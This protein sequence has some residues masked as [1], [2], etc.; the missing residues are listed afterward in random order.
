MVKKYTWIRVDKEAKKE[1]DERLKKLNNI[2]LKKMGI[3]NKSIHQIDLTKF[4]FK[5][6]IYISDLELKNMAKRKFGGKIC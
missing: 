4:L 2:D 3:K 1:L 6:K 5:N